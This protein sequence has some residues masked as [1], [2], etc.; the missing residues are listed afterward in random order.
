MFN[1][2]LLFTKQKILK[3]IVQQQKALEL[4]I[5]QCTIAFNKK[6]DNRKHNTVTIC[7]II[8]QECKVDL[9]ILAKLSVASANTKK[10]ICKRKI[11][12]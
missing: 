11:M 12:E 10:N 1:M 2:F 3:K 8:M 6:E 5:V 9:P 4:H 7:K